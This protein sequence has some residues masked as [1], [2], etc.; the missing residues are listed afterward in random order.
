LNV[1]QT[2]RSRI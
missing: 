1:G 2:K